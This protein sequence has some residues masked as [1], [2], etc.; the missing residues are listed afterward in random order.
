MKSFR[1]FLLLF[2]IYLLFFP[3][4]LDAQVKYKLKHK[5]YLSNG[6]VLQGD[7]SLVEDKK[8]LKISTPDHQEFIF[9]LQ[10][11]D[12]ILA[13]K[14]KP[15]RKNEMGY[16]HI[17][18]VGMIAR[19]MNPMARENRNTNSLLF[20]YSA[21]YTLLSG[22]S[23]GLGSGINLYERGLLVPIYA[24]IRGELGRGRVRPFLYTQIG[25]SLPLYK[26]SIRQN[27]WTGRIY[28]DFN[29]VGGLLLE[30][31]T[32]LKFMARENYAFFA[33][34]GWRFQEVTEKFD[35]WQTSVKEIHTARRLSLQI[36]CIF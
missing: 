34:L 19:D 36:G 33:A 28:E 30:G 17:L 9:P 29:A 10:E 14:F 2:V 3:K 1:L 6:W 13:S 12:S 18:H 4:N 24:D 11:V 15:A 32:G 25:T 5:V 16:R 22:L 31:G 21:S 35:Q 7:T 8:S 26:Y 27:R 20:Q 23:L